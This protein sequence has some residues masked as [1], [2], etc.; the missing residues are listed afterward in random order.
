LFLGTP[1]FAVPSLQCLLK[2]EHFEVV[3]VVTQPDRPA[4]RKR[5]LTPSPIKVFAEEQGLTVYTPEKVKNPEVLEQLKKT[6]ADV[7]VVVAFGQ[8][9][10]QAFIDLFTFG[11]VNI[12]SSIL[13]RWR[14]AAPMQRAIMAGDQ[15]TGV[16]L[17]KIVLKLDAG[18]VLGIRRVELTDD[19]DAIDLHD[20][21]KE[22][23]CELLEVE[24]MDYVRGNLGG[25]AQDESLVTYAKKLETSEGLIDWSKPARETLNQIRGLALGPKTWTFRD[26]KKLKILKAQMA[27][28]QGAPGQ[29]IM[30]K[31]ASRLP[32]AV[33]LC[34]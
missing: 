23:S 26:G 3:G 5:R 9:L 8:L 25:I 33:A 34:V 22:K 27:D 16:C 21:L 4:G 31:T 15:E 14:G 2:D 20:V 24:L 32:A 11:A 1:E 19:M 29:V 13:P 28:G 18:D 12:H 6:N 17:Q 10:P 30:T 7:A